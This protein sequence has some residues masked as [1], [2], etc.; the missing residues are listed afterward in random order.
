MTISDR[1]LYYVRVRRITHVQTAGRGGRIGCS[2]TPGGL[3]FEATTP[4]AFS[5]EVTRER[6]SLIVAAKHPVMNG[7]EDDVRAALQSPDEIRRSRRDAEVL[8]F[9]RA[10]RP[11]RWTCAV[12][13]HAA[14]GGL[15]VTAYPTDAVKEGEQIWIR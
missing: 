6:W 5:V 14:T 4:L 8:L 2:M 9:Y 13:R 15:L 1:V 11:G 12:V 7:R 10:E 3:L